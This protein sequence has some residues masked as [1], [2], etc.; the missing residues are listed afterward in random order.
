MDQ[1]LLF[2]FANLVGLCNCNYN[3]SNLLR[4]IERT[5]IDSNF[6]KHVDRSAAGWMGHGLLQDSMDGSLAV[7]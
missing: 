6:T 1:Q 5:C 2:S 3:S 4:N 7:H